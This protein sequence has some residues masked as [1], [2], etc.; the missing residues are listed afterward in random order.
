MHDWAPS[1]AVRRWRQVTKPHIGREP[2]VHSSATWRAARAMGDHDLDTFFVRLDPVVPAPK[3]TPGQTV[4]LKPA[5]M[6]IGAIKKSRASMPGNT[7]G[8]RLERS[9]VDKLKQ[10]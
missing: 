4:W 10:A 3:W 6:E 2:H 8:V 9:P 5:T 1:W 7:G